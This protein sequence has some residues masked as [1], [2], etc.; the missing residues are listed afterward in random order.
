MDN[1]LTICVTVASPGLF[2]GEAIPRKVRVC[3]C[4]SKVKTSAVS[5]SSGSSSSEMYFHKY[6][7]VVVGHRCSKSCKKCQDILIK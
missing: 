1:V 7:V 4:L 5:G 2:R 3:K 6:E